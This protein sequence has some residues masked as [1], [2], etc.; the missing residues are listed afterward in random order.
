MLPLT[1]KYASSIIYTWASVRREGQK[2]QTL[3]FQYFAQWHHEPFV[4]TKISWQSITGATLPINA[5]SWVGLQNWLGSGQMYL[6]LL[7][8]KFQG[9]VKA[10][11]NLRA[12]F[13]FCNVYFAIVP[14]IMWRA[15]QAPVKSSEAAKSVKKKFFCQ[16]LF[17]DEGRKA[18]STVGLPLRTGNNSLNKQLTAITFWKKYL[19]V[20]SYLV[21]P[22]ATAMDF[23]R[24]KYRIQLR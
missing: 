5:W 2:C 22:Q 6:R 24:E 21:I 20:F 1:F 4:L 9:H 17:W 18:Y 11:L 10:E 14:I 23:A 12:I 3:H 8:R 19:R 16:I 15:V 13:S 7:L